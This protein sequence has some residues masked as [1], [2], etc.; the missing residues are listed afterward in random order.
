MKLLLQIMSLLGCFVFCA[1]VHAQGLAIGVPYY[2][3]SD[4][5]I[6]SDHPV[7][8]LLRSGVTES[9]VSAKVLSEGET[10]V[11][12]HN[13]HLFGYSLLLAE[14]VEIS[15]SREKL[16]IQVDTRAQFSNGSRIS[17]ADVIFS[18]EKC[19]SNSIIDSAL[20]VIRGK[21]V[22]SFSQ[23][24]NWI[25]IQAKSTGPLNIP[26]LLEQLAACP[27]I[28]RRSSL[29]FGEELGA[30]TNLVGSGYYLLFDFI[31]G[32]ELILKPVSSQ[33]IAGSKLIALRR[34]RSEARAMSAL[35]VGNLDA[36]LSHNQWVVV[37]AEKDETLLTSKCSIYYVVFRRGL[38]FQCPRQLDLTTL[39]YSF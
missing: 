3:E 27:I 24:K 22:E 16:F 5:L 20:K 23:N 29:L 7:S 14:Q 12:I 10:N 4:T 13:D 17:G 9:L 33:N 6:Y 38:V 32:K 26:V 1:C 19:G 15:E 21:G 30:G 39:R 8:M 37:E 36:F 18:L 35:R 34:V 2:S 31:P 11:D 28:E 25:T